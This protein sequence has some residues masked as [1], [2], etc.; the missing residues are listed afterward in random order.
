MHKEGSILEKKASFKEYSVE[1]SSGL[2]HINALDTYTSIN[3]S[4][5]IRGKVYSVNLVNISY[6]VLEWYHAIFVLPSSRVKSTPAISPPPPQRPRRRRSEVVI[7]QGPAEGVEQVGDL[8]VDAVDAEV[9]D[10]GG[11]GVAAGRGVEEGDGAAER[12]GLG[13]VQRLPEPVDAVEHGVVQ[14]EDGV[15]GRREDVARAA[16]HDA[17]AGRVQAEEA[18]GEAALQLVLEQQHRARRRAHRDVE[19]VAQ[20]QPVGRREGAQVAAHAARVVAQEHRERHLAVLRRRHGAQV[21]HVVL[22][23][24]RRHAA[25]ALAGRDPDVAVG[26]YA[27]VVLEERAIAAEAGV[28]AVEERRCAWVRRVV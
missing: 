24:A 2:N 5:L 20:R 3:I 9:D 6:R 23:G 21:H 10:V 27:A 22:E 12:P 28:A 11:Q 17:V 13:G 26:G 18:V 8:E 4:L 1:A 25:A 15:R 14:E 7:A 19:D 16:A